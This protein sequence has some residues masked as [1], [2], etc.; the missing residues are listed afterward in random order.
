MYQELSSQGASLL[1]EEGIILRKSLI[2]Y[3]D[4]LLNTVPYDITYNFD[5]D[6]ISL[7]KALDVQTDVSSDTLIE[8]VSSYMKLMQQLCGISIFVFNN[9][10]CYFNE[11]NLQLLYESA[12]YNKINIINIEPVHT[13]HICREKCWIIDKDLC[14]IEA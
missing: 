1:Q 6:L 10:K 8:Q 14:I 12:R 9:L 11:S 4:Q 13:E 5:F 7:I 3:F 2:N